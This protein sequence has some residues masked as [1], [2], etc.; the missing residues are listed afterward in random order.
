M[1]TLIRW[2]KFNL[3]SAM[4]MGVQLA[5]LALFNRWMAGHYLYASAAAVEVTLL[6]N[7]V[8]H[9]H[10]TWRD[11]RDAA[12]PA[13]RLM[14]FHLSNG[15]VSMFGNLALM[16]LLIHEV[17]LQLVV[18]NLVAILCCSIANFSLGTNWAFARVPE[19][20]SLRESTNASYLYGHSFKS[21]S[22]VFPF[23]CSTVHAR[24]PT[25]QRTSKSSGPLAPIPLVKRGS[26]KKSG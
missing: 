12:T 1:N 11:R 25:P 26:V 6:H 22:L 5:A 16:P 3:V 9:W 23:T 20:E 19:T 2:G 10:Y 14:R 8:W 21:A 18:S 7:F 17:H 15:L 24:T 4:G 13:R